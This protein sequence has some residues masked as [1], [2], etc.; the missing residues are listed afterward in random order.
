MLQCFERLIGEGWGGKSK[1]SHMNNV[2]VTKR[3]NIN[4]VKYFFLSLA[5]RTFV[6]FPAQQDF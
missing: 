3:G 6:L 1:Y 4:W 5:H 2:W